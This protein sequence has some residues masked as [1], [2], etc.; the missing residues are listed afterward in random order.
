MLSYALLHLYSNTQTIIK[1]NRFKREV[2]GDNSQFRFQQ[3]SVGAVWLKTVAKNIGQLRDHVLCQIS[4]LNDHAADGIKAIEKKMRI[5]LGFERTKLR[6]TQG[7]FH[8]QLVAVELTRMPHRGYGE[9]QS[10]PNCRSDCYSHEQVRDCTFV[11]PY[12]E[13]TFN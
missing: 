6:F 2:V 9:I 12:P 4:I 3:D 1:T 5:Q 13:R 8:L 10:S 11:A 7:D